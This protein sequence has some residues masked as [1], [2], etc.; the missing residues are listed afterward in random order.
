M[1]FDS[2]NAVIPS[3]SKIM[4]HFM[5]YYLRINTVYKLLTLRKGHV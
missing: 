1:V 5:F 3:C 4:D 2:H